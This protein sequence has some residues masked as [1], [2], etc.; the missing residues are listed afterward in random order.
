MSFA[1]SLRSVRL[2]AG[3]TQQEL[4]ERSGVSRPNITAYEG[5][6]REP[7]F[8]SAD[9]LVR[10]AGATIAIEPP[11]RWSWTNGRR[12]YAVPS[13]LWRLEVEHAF[14]TFEAGSHLWWSG[15]ARSFDLADRPQRCRAYEIVLREGTPDDI[16]NVVDGAL[17]CDSWSDLVLPVELRV[18]WEPILPLAM[19]AA[20]RRAS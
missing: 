20:A 5:G 11:I 10:A 15:P 1:G 9:A 19:R 6:R 14:R 18:G 7:L 13:R 12:P 16:I 4:A 3:L 2:A 8:E 17:L